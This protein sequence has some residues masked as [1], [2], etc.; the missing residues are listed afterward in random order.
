MAE[1]SEGAGA[2][3]AAREPGELRRVLGV[4]AREERRLFGGMIKVDFFFF[5]RERERLRLATAHNSKE[6]GNEGLRCAHAHL[7]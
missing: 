4:R 5:L 2:R 7:A 6:A 3:F 1:C